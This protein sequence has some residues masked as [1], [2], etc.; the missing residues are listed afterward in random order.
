MWEVGQ[1]KEI[2][3]LLLILLLVFVVVPET[4]SSSPFEFLNCKLVICRVNGHGQL[5][6]FCEGAFSYPVTSPV[7]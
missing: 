1:T 7:E 4:S 5:D 6:K 2:E 3:L